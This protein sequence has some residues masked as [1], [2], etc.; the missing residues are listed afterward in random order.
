VAVLTDAGRK[1]QT[2]FIDGGLLPIAPLGELFE[3][4]RFSFCHS[5]AGPAA[6][7]RIAD[8][9]LFVVNHGA[10]EAG[11]RG[12]LLEGSGAS[13]EIFSEHAIEFD[14]LPEEWHP[15][16][17]GKASDIRI[18]DCRAF[19]ERPWYF[20]SARSNIYWER[21]LRAAVALGVVT[22][23]AIE[24]DIAARQLRPSVALVL[25]PDRAGEWE[26]IETVA[27]LDR[28]YLPEVMTNSI[29]NVGIL[30]AMVFELPKRAREPKV[31]TPNDKLASTKV[32]K[33][34]ASRAAVPVP[35]VSILRR[36]PG[37]LGRALQDPLGY[38]QRAI[39][40]LR[41]RFN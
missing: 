4:A 39:D 26:L 5:C 41:D 14:N 6:P 20:V 13:Y 1:G 15:K 38:A 31:G 16:C 34:Y 25:D 37:I 24:A 17:Y 2:L 21:Y 22:P 3:V 8:L 28:Q 19:A 9:D 30:D 33:Q 23:A 29:E 12:A 40:H 7:Q 10:A 18:L 35:R 11:I 36:L 32:P 27:E